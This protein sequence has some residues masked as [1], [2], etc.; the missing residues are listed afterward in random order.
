[1]SGRTG[2]VEGWVSNVKSVGRIAFI[3]VID[4]LQLSPITV[5]VKREQVDPETWTVATGVKIGSALRVEGVFPEVV[6]SR[7]GREI[8]ATKITVLA[9]PLELPP[10]DL[11]G[12]TPASFDLYIEYRYLALRLPRFRAIFLARSKLIGFAREYLSEQGFLEINTPKI[13]GA[14]AEGGATLFALDYFGMKAYLSQSPQLYKQMLMCGVPRV[15]EI[16]PYFRA[17]KFSTPRHLNESWGL[18]VEMAFI[19]SEEDVMKVLEDFVRGAIRYLRSEMGDD[20]RANGLELLEEPASIPRVP[21]SRAIEILNSM[22]FSIQWGDDLDT[23]A[24]KAL[25]EYFQRQGYPMYFI[26]QYPW[27]AKPF[28]IMKEGERLSKAFDLDI[29]GIEV[30]SGGQREHRYAELIANLRAKGLNPA[31]FSF[32]TQAFKYGMPPHGGF[33][34]G[35]D[36]LLMT[37]LGL[38]NIREVVLFPRDRFRLVP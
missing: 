9:E 22:G 29:S 26:T 15:F 34:L 23:Q 19:N 35:L 8:Q 17:E 4:G 33:G 7:K 10:I 24:E 2:I 20:L 31:E 16:T 25:G 12:K 13:V 5:V 6:I 37:L 30:A 1:M 28:Y 3:E 18:D 27:D 36:R 14:G 32:Y 21:Y 11:T 38:S